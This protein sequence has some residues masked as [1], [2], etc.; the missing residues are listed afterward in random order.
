MGFRLKRHG[1]AQVFNIFTYFY[2]DGD[3]VI[4]RGT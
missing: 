3:K 1:G 4:V 2:Y